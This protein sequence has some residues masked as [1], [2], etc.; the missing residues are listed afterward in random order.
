MAGARRF[1]GLWEDPNDNDAP[2]GAL[3]VATNVVL[4]R[5]GCIDPRRGSENANF[6]ALSGTVN[7][8]HEYESV[9]FAHH[10]TASISKSTDDGATWTSM[11][12]TFTP[13]DVNTRVRFWEDAG[14]L[15]VLTQLG[16]YQ[17][18]SPTG[19][20]RLT[21]APAAL[22]GTATLRRTSNETGAVI[23]GTAFDSWAGSQ[24]AY[25]LVWGYNDGNARLQ[26]GEPS[27]RFLVTNPAAIEVPAASIT[28]AGSAVVTVDGVTHGFTT[29]EYVD[30]LFEGTHTDFVEGRFEVTVT[31]S[32]TFTYNDGGGTPTGAVGSNGQFGFLS[33]N[34][35]V[36]AP[37][38]SD[39]TTSHFLQLYA[40]SLSASA[41]TEPSDAMALVYERAP[42][43]LEVTA[44]TMS[45]TDIVPDALRGA[46]LYTSVGTI[47]DAKARP[48]QAHD[49]AV[50]QGSTFYVNT[51][52]TQSVELQLL[53]V[54]GD[55]GIVSGDR[56]RIIETSSGS[57]QNSWEVA[58]EAGSADDYGSG[59]FRVYTAGTA[60]Q[61][62]A[63]T[64]RSIV[65]CVNG[66]TVGNT[67]KVRAEYVS[68]E[69]EAPG[70]VRIYG[71]TPAVEQFSPYIRIASTAPPRFFAP[72]VPQQ[73]VILSGQ[74]SRLTNV[75]TVNTSDSHGL[76]TG[77]TIAIVD[78]AGAEANFPIGTKTVTVTD[79]NTFTYAESG[80]NAT[81]AS[82]YYM[83]SQP[84]SA[85]ASK[86]SAFTNGLMWS[87][88]G[89]PWAV[90]RINFARVGKD[91]STL[92]RAIPT[93]DRLMLLT[94]D[95]FYQLTGSGGAW[96]ISEYDVT[97][98]LPAY[99]MATAAGGRV[100]A[101]TQQGV[102]EMADSARIISRP[103]KKTIS[104]ILVA[105][106]SPLRSY[107]FVVPYE[108]E[109]RVV[110]VL[111]STSLNV[112]NDIAYVWHMD[113]GG[114]TKW[115]FSGAESETARPTCGIVAP[116][117]DKLYI[118][119]TNG[120]VIREL[121]SKTYTDQV[122]AAYAFSLI[123]PYTISSTDGSSY[124][125]LNTGTGNIIV[126]TS[127]RNRTEGST[128]TITSVN[129]SNGRI[130]LSSHTGWTN[131]DSVSIMSQAIQST[132]EPVHSFAGA[133]GEMKLYERGSLVFRDAR[134]TDM[135]QTFE[136]DL[137]AIDQA[138]LEATLAP[139]GT[140]TTD[141][142]AEA[143]TIDFLVAR[144]FQRGSR[145]AMRLSHS[146]GLERYSLQSFDI[147]TRVCSRRPGK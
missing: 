63:D 122:D 5:A 91:G 94:D 111:P 95:G 101:L 116:S 32:N 42:T 84:M 140:T 135:D 68:A 17:L 74:M 143:R 88:P 57:L 45:I 24:R 134:F 44:G 72:N 139:A 22:Q 41:T 36:A 96:N 113:V 11:S 34:V 37:F 121:K 118:G 79:P 108:S 6:T 80:N 59:I 3:A 25:R 147:Q 61:N 35:T 85:L 23:G 1:S 70:R 30:V 133:P 46:A 146:N 110:F 69:T 54:G 38:P 52:G 8:L 2:E 127:L 60:A 97:L 13:V 27:G 131:G 31:D 130:G 66:Q 76:S 33:R 73:S 92:H 43:N 129:T 55:F 106:L 117:D 47:L 71:Q 98:R 4:D 128:S 138:S 21:G 126:G 77:Q 87:Q 89:E 39:V 115:T 48:P 100:Y 90:P 112:Y 53:A 7:R 141:G 93:R 120:N 81:S 58:L 102:A 51:A 26:L 114:W 144:R 124:I 10:S 18:D 104:D 62:I 123:G 99:E 107:G 64:A 86:N 83:L 109:A 142:T 56:I 9:L 125:T 137:C 145:M 67:D 40:S 29:G 20:W 19:T 136:T 82:V 50:F 75:V 16:T 65:R 119:S 15:F 14:S 132:I 12:G 105:A 49:A 103:I 78:N 28:K